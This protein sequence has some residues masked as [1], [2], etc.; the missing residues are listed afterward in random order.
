M[1]K[2][3]KRRRKKRDNSYHTEK[4]KEWVKEKARGLA[5]N[6]P[7]SEVWFREE[8][9]KK[10]KNLGDYCLESNVY[11][12]GKIP[13]LV[14]E[15]LRVVIEIDGSVHELVEV[16]E[17]DKEKDKLYRQKG[18]E[19]IR[20]SAYDYDSFTA[21]FHRLEELNQPKKAKP[22]KTSNPKGYKKRL[23]KCNLCSKKGTEWVTYKGKSFRYCETCRKKV[24]I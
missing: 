15:T 11:C 7:K 12:Y 14:S 1:D 18:Y 3:E 9:S 23:E 2:K 21:C 22:P 24:I 19:V 6:L 4:Q 16:A 5:N 20:V 17:K 13:D 8:L 10:F